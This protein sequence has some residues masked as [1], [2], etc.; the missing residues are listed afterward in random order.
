[1]GRLRKGMKLLLLAAQDGSTQQSGSADYEHRDWAGF[2]HIL[3]H[4]DRLCPVRELHLEGDVVA[5]HAGGGHIDA[6]YPLAIQHGA[7]D[8]YGEDRASKVRVDA[9]T[10]QRAVAVE[11]D[12]SPGASISAEPTAECAPGGI[13]RVAVCDE[14]KAV[15]DLF[16]DAT[17]VEVLV[18]PVE[19]DVAVTRKLAGAEATEGESR[20]VCGGGIRYRRNRVA[21][22]L[23]YP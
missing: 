23:V 6:A 4:V 19:D 5:V 18:D 10:G 9:I 1:M 20:G 17:V 2:W 12:A 13:R 16:V 3:G 11:G 15:A 7:R 21:G 22:F 14:H 8:R